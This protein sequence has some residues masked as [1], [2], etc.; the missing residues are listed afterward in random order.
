MKTFKVVPEIQQFESCAEFAENYQLGKGDLIFLS[1]RVLEKNLKGLIKEGAILINYRKYGSGEPTDIM[2]EGIC[3]EL[4]GKE[5]NRVIAIGGGTILDVA[6]LFALKTV[7]PVVKL[8]QKELPI[9]KEKELILVPTTCGTG[10]EVT[11]ISI[12][13][14]T[15]IDSKFGLAVDELYPDK[16]VL[17]PE[18]LADLPMKFFSTSSIDALIHAIESFTSPK[19]TDFTRMYSKKAMKMILK[20]YQKIA[21]EGEEARKPLM[22]EFQMA[23]TYAGIAFG[24]AGCAAVHA[25]SYPLGSKYH[26]PHGEANYAL[27]TEVYKTYMWLK[28]EGVIRELNSCLSEILECPEAMVYDG[29]ES[30]L[31]VIFPRKALREYGVTAADIDEFAEIVM[32]KQ[33]RLMANNYTELDRSVVKGIYQK[34]L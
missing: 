22:G 21:L 9:E 11:N 26:I 23:A 34:L 1:E 24:N 8:F 15:A 30:L 25:M 14:L 32:T 7:S 20:G 16:A 12:L 5:Y 13:E 3:S 2:V 10:S 18:L 28:P 4:S 6:K 27:F 31:S 33:G 19:A 17:I 29:L